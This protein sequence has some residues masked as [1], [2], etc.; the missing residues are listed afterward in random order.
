MSEPLHIETSFDEFYR[1]ILNNVA[2]A[3]E[4]PV[5]MLTSKP[6]PEEPISLVV[7]F[8]GEEFIIGSNINGTQLEAEDLG[9]RIIEIEADI[10]HLVE[11]LAQRPNEMSISASMLTYLRND[12]EQSECYVPSRNQRTYTPNHS[13]HNKRGKFKRSKR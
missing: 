12:A 4:I 3:F 11:P 1:L 10:S 6:M 13:K 8:N 2:Q 5:H 7:T 9:K